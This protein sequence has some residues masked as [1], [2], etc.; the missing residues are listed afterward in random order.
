M[1]AAGWIRAPFA[2]LGALLVVA[3][4]AT[5]GGPVASAAGKG[6]APTPPGWVVDKVRFEPIDAPLTAEAVGTYRGVVE[7]GRTGG[8]LSVIND[9]SLDDYLFGISEV[10]VSWPSEA[11]RAQAIAART[12]ALHEM[13]KTTGGAARAAGAHICATDACQV[14]TGLAKE[15]RPGAE[16]WVD[17]VRSTSGQVLLHKGKPLLAKYSS[18]NG[19]RTT[20]GGQP[21]LRSVD[22][23]DDAASPL[24]QWQSAIALPALTAIFGPPG[25]VVDATRTGDTVVLAWEAPD[26]AGGVLT[27][28]HAIGALDFRAAVNAALPDPPG[29]PMALPSIRYTVRADRA[30]GVAVVD[31]RGWG[32]GIGMSQYGALRKAQRGM[33]APDILAAYYSGIRPTALPAA[34]LPSSVRVAVALDVGNVTVA[35]EGRFRVVDGNGAPMAIATSGAW[36][37]VPAGKGVRVIPP[38][39]AANPLAV[40]PVVVD[41][42]PE[43]GEPLELRLRLSTPA[44]VRLTVHPPSAAAQ[45]LEPRLLDAGESAHAL[46]AAPAPGDYVVDIQADAGVGRTATVPVRF[47]VG[48]RGAG[49]VTEVGVP[50]GGRHRIFAA[51]AAATGPSPST[52]DTGALVVAMAALAAVAEGTRRQVGHARTAGTTGPG[53]SPGT[54]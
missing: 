51:P 20:A 42:A 43:T 16:A 41:G 38:P 53:S 22:D 18:S 2:V 52:A 17:A 26:G 37:V 14:Y 8:G 32:H 35:G 31:G 11:Q 28:T 49:A 10:P 3:V 33:K 45:A 24:H 12:Y 46:P 21:Y 23:P 4:V 40:E 30:A 34:Q 6:Q 29:L 25:Q 54:D 19:G 27:G 9:V 15:R 7:V 13:G 36:Q 39:G 44:M 48:A 1:R 50:D 47:T 5:A